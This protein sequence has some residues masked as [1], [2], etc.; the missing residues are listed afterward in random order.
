ML[1]SVGSIHLL[2]SK[3]QVS[4][5]YK[6]TSHQV[7]QAGASHNTVLST[8][9]L[10]AWPWPPSASTATFIVWYHKRFPVPSAAPP[11]FCKQRLLAAILEEGDG[12]SPDLCVGKHYSRSPSVHLYNQYPLSMV[13]GHRENSKATRPTHK[14]TLMLPSTP[15]DL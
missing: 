12:Q 7:A 10:L 15:E 13:M 11:Q 1:A 14:V 3:S 4:I 8:A 6:L 9:L 2:I 5:E